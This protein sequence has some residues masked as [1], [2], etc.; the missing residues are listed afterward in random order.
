LVN[1]DSDVLATR[2]QDDVSRLRL[3]KFSAD[4]MFEQCRAELKQPL[5]QQVVPALYGKQLV[6]TPIAIKHVMNI[7]DM[8]GSRTERIRAEQLLR[9]IRVYG[10]SVET[11][12]VPTASTI[13]HQLKGLPL[14]ACREVVV[15]QE[16]EVSARVSA[17]TASKTIQARPKEVFG[18]A[19]TLNI[20]TLTSNQRFV[21]AAAQA[22]CHLRVI[23]HSPRALLTDR[24]ESFI[25]FQ[26]L[27][28]STL[29]LM[30]SAIWF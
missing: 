29:V 27:V 23:Y 24:V 13:G 5:L 21:Q 11:P 12:F 28:H 15:D 8:M 18:V 3:N 22:G 30:C 6:A 10:P 16:V 17:L 19:D 7:V 4:F 14:P 2:R 20:V 1:A 26:G 25:D 9:L